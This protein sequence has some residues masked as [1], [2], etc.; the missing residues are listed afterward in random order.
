MADQTKL[1]KRLETLLKLPGNLLCVDCGKRGPRWASANLGVFMCID[2]SGIHRNLG[3]HI[4]FVRS[5]NLDSWTPEQ[6]AVSIFTLQTLLYYI[7]TRINSSPPLERILHS[8]DNNFR[9]NVISKRHSLFFIVQFICCL[10]G[11][12]EMG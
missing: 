3:V 12:G 6:V 7:F 11:H 4:S 9:I 10:I 8:N 2:C 1:R 5:V